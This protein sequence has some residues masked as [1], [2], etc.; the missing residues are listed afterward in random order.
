MENRLCWGDKPV[1]KFSNVQ[2]AL[3]A[4]PEE[5]RHAFRAQLNRMPDKSDQT[6]ATILASLTEGK[7][8]VVLDHG[9]TN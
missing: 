2:S 3:E 9:E 6:A 5:V 7:I 4:V 1:K 8:R